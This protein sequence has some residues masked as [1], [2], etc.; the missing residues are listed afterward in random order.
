MKFNIFDPENKELLKEMQK[1]ANL[2]DEDLIKLESEGRK[3][4]EK[5]TK[6]LNPGSGD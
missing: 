1:N 3:A 5:L 2:S 6:L 4:Q